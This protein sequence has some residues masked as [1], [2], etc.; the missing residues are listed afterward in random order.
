MPQ[1]ATDPM[2]QRE[3]FAAF[4]MLCK[5]LDA[6]RRLLSLPAGDDSELAVGVHIEYWQKYGE[7]SVGAELHPGADYDVRRTAD[8]LRALAAI[9][10]WMSHMTRWMADHSFNNRAI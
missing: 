6:I 4:D 7:I 1:R 9:S 2:L 5:N 10:D 3:Y 8:G